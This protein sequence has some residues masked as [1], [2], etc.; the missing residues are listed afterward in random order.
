MG[1]RK[2]TILNVAADAVAESAFFIEGKGLPKTAKIFVDEAFKFFQSLSDARIEHH[3]CNYPVWKS[4]N[5]RC[6]TFKKYVFAY[7][8]FNDETVV[9]E[10]VPS[11][12]IYW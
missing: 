3:Q 8:Y 12:L 6:V 9:C 2:V 10:F 1:K 5:Y 4:L 11:K 7:L